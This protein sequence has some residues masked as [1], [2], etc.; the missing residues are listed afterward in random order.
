MK[1]NVLK[2]DNTTSSTIDVNFADE[3]ATTSFDVAL[4]NRVKNQ[5]L[6]Q[7]SKKVKTRSEVRGGKAKPYKQKGTGRARQGSLNGP[8]QTGGGV[9]HGPKQDTTKLKLNKKY[10][11]VALSRVLKDYI[12]GNKLSLVELSEDKEALRSFFSNYNKALFVYSDRNFEGLKYLRNLPNIKSVNMSDM[13]LFDLV[14]CQNI[15][16]D[17]NLKDTL[18]KVLN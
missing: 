4:I 1:V 10:K 12:N 2:L 9:A 13:S 18:L 14:N 16:V 17:T 3:T 11:S 8:H 15:L 6:K 5:A 7:G